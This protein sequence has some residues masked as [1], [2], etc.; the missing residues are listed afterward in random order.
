MFVYGA[1]SSSDDT[2]RSQRGAFFGRR[3]G[4]PLRAHQASLMQTLLP[5][6]AL[7]RTTPAPADLA[8]LFPHAVEQVR[9]EI[10]FGGGEH[11]AAQARAHPDAG[12]IGCEPFV[13]GMAKMLAAIE[14]QQLQ[15]VRLHFGDAVE[16]LDWL[17]DA[18][19]ARIDIL[20]PDP[21]PKRRHWKRR[22]LQDA[23]IT[24]LGRVLRA[25][26]AVHFATDW[27]DYAAWT[28]ECFLRTPAFVWTAERAADW[29]EPWPDYVTTRY[30]AKA[31]R[32]GRISNY[33][34][35]RRV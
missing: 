4:H 3:K 20:Y 18:A 22:L 30:E 6:L 8:G 14:D 9:L 33:F 15:N 27:A 19:L 5:R 12:F 32:E 7:D 11:L 29:R 16:L 28:L 24:A 21:W 10:G 35:F 2:H 31:K 23:T 34:I 1:M 25:G 17:P 13:N 26:G